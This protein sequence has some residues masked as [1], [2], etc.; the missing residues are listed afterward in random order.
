MGAKL[1]C[2]SLVLEDGVVLV[3]EPVV[4]APAS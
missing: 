1:A 3:F 2:D 4:V